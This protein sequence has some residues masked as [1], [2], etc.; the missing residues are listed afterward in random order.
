VRTLASR[1]QRSTRPAIE[2]PVPTA[3]SAP[4]G[5]TAGPDGNLWFTEFY[6]NKIG[7]L[8]PERGQPELRR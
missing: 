3:G 7:V 1:V 8:R 2:F 4:V 6:G 5:I